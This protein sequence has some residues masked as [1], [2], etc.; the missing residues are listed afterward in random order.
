MATAD[1][2]LLFLAA[3]PWARLLQGDLRPTLLTVFGMA[4]GVV[5]FVRGFRTWRRLRLIQDT[6]TSKVRSLALGRVEI[7]GQATEKAELAAPFTGA[8]CV[9]YR[10][11]IEE[12]VRSGRSR[13]WRSVAQGDSH[14]WPFYVED[15]TGRILVDPGGAEFHVPSDYRE[16][17]PDLSGAAGS[18]LASQGVSTHGLLGFRRKLRLSEWHIAPGETLYVLGTAQE[19]GSLV[20]ERRVRIAEKLAALKADPEAMA[21]FDADGDG[22]ISQEEWEM[23]RRLVVQGIER[24][25]AE[26]RVVIGRGDEGQPFFVAD[27][28]ES[29]IVKR[30]RWSALGGIF[31][32]ALLSLGSLGGL[33]IRTGLLDIGR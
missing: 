27:R 5:F 7:H 25:G 18:Y 4:A 12:Q 33:L 6:P 11:E 32:G 26:D 16:V 2:S 22:R 8:A 30:H 15:D 29:E 3:D 9:W 31:G 28:P 19:R 10:W 23:A 13:R 14:A 24:E 21:H 17:D 20:H 1:P